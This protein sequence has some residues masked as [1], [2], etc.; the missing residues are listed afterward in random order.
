MYLPACVSFVNC[1][2]F[3][4]LLLFEI[5]ESSTVTKRYKHSP[6]SSGAVKAKVISVHD[7]DTCDL[8]FIETGVLSG[9]NV[10]WLALTLQNWARV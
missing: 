5:N 8:V 7:G 3:I 2:K 4:I 9:S 1:D 10:V 6:P